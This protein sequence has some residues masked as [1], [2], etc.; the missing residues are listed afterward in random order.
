MDAATRLQQIVQEQTQRMLDAQAELDKARLEQQQKQAKAAKSAKE[1]TRYLSKLVDRQ[2]KT[3]HVQPRVIQ[4]YLKRYEGDYQTEYLRIACA[5]LVNQYQGVISEATQ[6]VGSSFNWQGHEYSLEGLY[7]Q[8][9]S[10]LGRPPFQSKYWFYDMLTDALVD[11]EQLLEDFDNPQTRRVYS[12]VVKKTDE[13]YSEVIDYNGAVLTTDDIFLLQAIVDGN[14]YRDVL[15][16][17]G[18]TLK[19]YSKSVE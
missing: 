13:N 5:L 3:G 17:G 14:G 18:G 2:L 1:V 8:I 11:R 16:N 7:S 12:E 10:I 4:E 15:T 19:A 6:I 9:V